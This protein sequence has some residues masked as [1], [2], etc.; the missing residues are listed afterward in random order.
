MQQFNCY[1]LIVHI[2]SGGTEITV[3]GKNFV[4]EGTQYMNLTQMQINVNTSDGPKTFDAHN[5][6]LIVSEYVIQTS[7]YYNDMRFYSLSECT[8]STI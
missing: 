5:Y 8:P 2:F 7:F 3:H 1:N 4:F 6:D